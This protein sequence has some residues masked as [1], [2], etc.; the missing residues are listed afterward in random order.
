MTM[1]INQVIKSDNKY[2][3]KADVTMQGTDVGIA[4]CSMGEVGEDIKPVLHFLGNVLKP[5]V[6]NKTNA[7]VLVSLFGEESDAWTGQLICVY[8]DPSVQYQGVA[9]G[10]LKVRPSA[11][12]TNPHGVQMAQAALQSPS[13]PPSPPVDSYA[14]DQVANAQTMANYPNDGSNPF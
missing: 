14:A 3:S 1:N 2:L 12:A 9:V 7:S 6:L 8:S 5:M 10:G 11:H 13:A 4:A